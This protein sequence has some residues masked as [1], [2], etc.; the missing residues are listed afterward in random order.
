MARGRPLD[1]LSPKYRARIE[2]GLA[3]GKSRQAARGH[4]AK[5]HVVR[6]ERE[7]ER[8]GIARSENDSIRRWYRRTFNPRGDAGKPSEETVVEVA[9]KRGYPWFQRYRA[10]WEVIRRNYRREVRAGTYSSRGEG[11]LTTMGA[12]APSSGG[13]SSGGGSSGGGSSGGGSSGDGSSGEE[14]Y[15]DDYDYDLEYEDEVPDES[16]LYYH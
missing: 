16:W 5:E 1:Q 12:P 2:R 10:K 14:D 8:L 7:R 15:G 6:K 11:Y 4:V 13:G 9:S 3:R